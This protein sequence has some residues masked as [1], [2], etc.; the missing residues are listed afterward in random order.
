M[1]ILK[2]EEKDLEEILQ[3]QYLAFNREAEAF[4][5]FNIEPMTQTI[6]ALKEEYKKYIFLKVV[7]AAGKIIASIRGYI[8]NGTSYIGKTLVHPEYQGRGIGTGMIR[9]LEEI[10][11]ASRYEI[12]ASVRCPE[13]IKLYERLGYVRFKE[14]QTENNGFIYLEKI[15]DWH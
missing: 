9:K 4:N 8:E 1:E 5:D 6:D 15:N 11:Q 3:V 14:T 2:A 13:N 10:N 12:N 7:N